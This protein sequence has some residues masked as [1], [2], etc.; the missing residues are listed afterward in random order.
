MI[1]IYPVSNFRPIECLSHTQSIRQLLTNLIALT[2]KYVHMYIALRKCAYSPQK[3]CSHLLQNRIKR[4]VDSSAGSTNHS[5]VSLENPSVA[6]TCRGKYLATVQSPFCCKICA[7]VFKVECR[8][9]YLLPSFKI[10]IKSCYNIILPFC[11]MKHTY[12]YYLQECN[13]L[14]VHIQFH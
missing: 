10:S 11:I 9:N 4:N 12:R 6:K 14:K 7:L 2:F 8:T 3:F 13:S 1:L 5:C